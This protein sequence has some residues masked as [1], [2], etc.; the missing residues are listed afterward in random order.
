MTTRLTAE[1]GV[2]VRSM[3]TVEGRLPNMDWMVEG[4]AAERKLGVQRDQPEPVRLSRR[5]PLSPFV[6]ATIRVPAAATSAP[7]G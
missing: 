6:P 1:R 4:L 2:A 5:E 7:A 3:R